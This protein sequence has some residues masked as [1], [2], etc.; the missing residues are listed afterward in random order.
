DSP[1]ARRVR[2]GSAGALASGSERSSVSERDIDRE[3]EHPFLVPEVLHQRE[4]KIK[5]QGQGAARR[6]ADPDA[7]Y[8]GSPVVVE[9]GRVD[10]RARIQEGAS[11]KDVF[12]Q[13]LF[14]FSAGE[15]TPGSPDR[16]VPQRHGVVPD[17]LGR[18]GA[19]IKA[20]EAVPAEVVPL[21]HGHL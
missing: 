10:T 15:E 16:V 18:D 14:H 17:A 6:E 20:A 4:S 5:R 9:P 7:A 12:P 19:E 11:R 3:G 13:R 1:E 21:I 8:A 2:P